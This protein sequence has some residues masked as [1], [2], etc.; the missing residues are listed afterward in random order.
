[1]GGHVFPWHFSAVPAACVHVRYSGE[2]GQD[3]LN[4]SFTGFDP[5]RSA[6]RIAHARGDSFAGGSLL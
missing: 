3:L 6:S 4:L 5:K 2:S 1:L